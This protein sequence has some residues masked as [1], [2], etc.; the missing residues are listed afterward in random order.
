MSKIIVTGGA[1]FIGSNLTDAL[2]EKGHDVLVIDNLS[3]GN[4]EYVNSKAKFHEVDILEIEKIKPLFEG[5][6]FVFHQAALPRVP[7]SVEKP[8]ETNDINVGGTINV[9]IAAKDARVKK[10]IYAA[11]SSAYGNQTE[12][13]LKEDMPCS[14]SSPYGLQKYVGELYC[15]IFLA[16]RLV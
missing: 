6:D 2:I 14:P 5:V 13:P 3:T 4:R 8:K 15:K 9:L 7:L 16:W 1:G 11:S 12:L 10:V